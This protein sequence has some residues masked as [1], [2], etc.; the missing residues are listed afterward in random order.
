MSSAMH[1]IF[2]IAFKET[3]S[4]WLSWL[5]QPMIYDGGLCVNRTKEEH[6]EHNNHPDGKLTI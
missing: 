6:A 3:K 4:D 2:D 1:T 5:G